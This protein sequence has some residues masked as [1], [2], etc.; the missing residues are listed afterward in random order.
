M[1]LVR[2]QVSFPADSNNSEDKV[3]NNW[4]FDIVDT[5]EGQF[6]DLLTAL[7][8]FYTGF[9][10]LRSQDYQWN[11]G[12]LKLY[13]LSEPEPRAPFYDALFDTGSAG[14]TSAPPELAICMSF[15]GSQIS[16][17]RQARRRGRVYLGPL[18]SIALSTTT[19][20]ISDS[21]VST[22]QTIGGNFLAA[23]NSSTQYDWIILSQTPTLN[24]VP[25][26]NGWVDN[27]PDIQRRRGVEPTSRLTFG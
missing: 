5:D 18:A 21:A 1:T 12:R 4:G 14:S 10:T 16:G 13:D 8:A 20:R 3:V 19:G 25:V 6:S 27:A 22:V 7:D 26:D 11:A 2:A 15:Q 9:G 23:S 17:I 24:G